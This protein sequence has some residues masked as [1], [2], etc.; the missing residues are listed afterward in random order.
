M[1][2]SLIII[3]SV[4]ALYSTVIK[5]YFFEKEQV[6]AELN[7]VANENTDIM[8]K[9]NQNNK[10]D[11]A[12]VNDLYQYRQD[13]LTQVNK[14]NQLIKD[15][16]TM[17]SVKKMITENKGVQRIKD[18]LNMDQMQ[19]LQKFVKNFGVKNIK[20]LQANK[21]LGEEDTKKFEV[22]EPISLEEYKKKFNIKDQ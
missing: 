3:A 15:D 17:E 10:G 9:Y 11:E 2:K 19:E 13:M 21:I 18:Q 1:I 6:S 7:K 20:F 16:V 8:A 14:V 22:T 4:L 12:G 5:N